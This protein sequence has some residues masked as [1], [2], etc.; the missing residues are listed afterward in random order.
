MSLYPAAL[1]NLIR[2]LS[3]LPGIGPKTAERLALHL[4]RAPEEQCQALAAGIT[5]M[6]TTIGLCSRCGGLSDQ[7]LCRICRNPS[8]DHGVL[9]VVEQPAD[10]VALEK[11][12][13]FKGCYHI[14]HGA[15]S[16]MDGVGPDQIRLKELFL[17][18]GQEGVTEVVL[19][20]GTS[21]EGEAT[22][23]YIAEQLKDLDIKLTRIASGVPV[24]GD[25]KFI[26]QV[27][28][29]RAMETRHAF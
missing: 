6:K 29:K 1:E 16:P 19:A 2:Q 14:L 8:R 12:D 9:C 28:L 25:L 15:L 10:M 20:T 17:R 24:G 18:V 22:A 21:L 3:R 11:S 27:T 4:L 5:Q 23:A 13:A 26:D 7:S